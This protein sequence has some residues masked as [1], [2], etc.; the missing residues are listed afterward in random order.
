MYLC[1]VSIIAAVAYFSWW[2]RPSHTCTHVYIQT[3]PG[4]NWPHRKD[5]LH[6]HLPLEKYRCFLTQCWPSEIHSLPCTQ[7]TLTIHCLGMI[8]ASACIPASIPMVTPQSNFYAHMYTH[9]RASRKKDL[10]P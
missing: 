6:V 3:Y 1:T 10:Y 9:T 7:A 4:V 8:F 5:I 2:C